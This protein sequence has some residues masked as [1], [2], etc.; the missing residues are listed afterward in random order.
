MRGG[1]V[2]R[3]RGYGYMHDNNFASPFATALDMTIRC[4]EIPPDSKFGSELVKHIQ[5]VLQRNMADQ[6]RPVIPCI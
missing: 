2:G 3:Q 1:G 4:F 5:G 6:F